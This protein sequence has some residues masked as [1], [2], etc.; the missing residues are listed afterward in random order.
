MASTLEENKLALSELYVA[1]FNRAPDAEG[2]AYW[3]SEIEDNSAT[4]A[5]IAKNWANEQQEFVDTYGE[6]VDYDTFIDEVYTNVLDRN[7]DEDGKTYWKDD[8]ESENLD[9]DQFIL[10]VINGAKATTGSS[11]DAA[12]L[13]NKAQVGVNVAESGIED[14]E[15][16]TNAVKSV[17]SDSDTVEIVND[18]IAMAKDDST[19]VTKAASILSS[20]KELIS[21]DDSEDSTLVEEVKSL[22]KDVA[23]KRDSGSVDGEEVN[24]LSESLNALEVTIKATQYNKDFIK[25]T[26]NIVDSIVLNLDNNNLQTSALV[27]MYSN[28]TPSAPPA[29]S[30]TTA[31]IVTTAGITPSATVRLQTDEIGTGYIVLASE[32]VSSLSD[33]RALSD[34]KYNS[35][36]I[37]AV[38][39]YFQIAMTGLIS[40]T[41]KV[42]A[43]DSAGNLSEAYTN[44]VNVSTNA[45]VE[46]VTSTEDNGAYEKND[47]IEITVKFSD[48]VLVDTSGGVP[49]ITLETGDADK[50]AIYSRGSGSDTLVFIY[51]VEAGDLASDLD[52]TATNALALNGGT[53]N[54]S[55]NN[56]SAILTL[57]ALGGDDSIAGSKDISVDG[58]PGPDTSIVVFDLIGGTSSD[59]SSRSFADDVAYT[60]YIRMDSD[61]MA[62]YSDANS[63]TGTWGKW[64]NADNLGSDDIIILV[65]DGSA[66]SRE[67]NREVQGFGTS[68]ASVHYSSTNDGYWIVKIGSTGKVR[69]FSN[70]QSSTVDMWDTIILNNPNSTETFNQVFLTTM[71]VGIMTSQGLA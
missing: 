42:Y 1:Y 46:S 36:E 30:D 51:T 15:F 3:L 14:E 34:N 19:A 16:A 33:I 38:D 64:S 17:T 28:S 23:T 2:L 5:S 13:A 25:D 37:T 56:Q 48:I 45:I 21:S 57:P 65:G 40:D 18:L 58:G 29:P 60:I 10:A 63:G 61:S 39:T 35:V 71:P 32:S 49:S 67:D 70:G 12:L 53:I 55:A 8:L 9:K 31:P 44:T 22:V 6:D 24:T 52:Y 26:A 4:V 62:L 11:E 50:E 54:T 59:H 41:Y 68:F 69:H 66:I 7:A 47:T 43:S 20:V 27:T